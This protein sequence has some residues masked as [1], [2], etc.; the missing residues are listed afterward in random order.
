MEAA[1]QIIELT[2]TSSSSVEQAVQTAITTA[3][4][5]VRK[6][7]VLSRETRGAIK[8]GR[9]PSGSHRKGWVQIEA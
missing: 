9:L 1:L 8:D 3:A 5:S 7:V 4:Q 2:G 6:H